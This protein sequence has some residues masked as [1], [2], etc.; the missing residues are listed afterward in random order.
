MA[1]HHRN[2][3]LNKLI[4]AIRK[5]EVV[6]WVGSG[7]SKSSGYPSGNE[8]S[9]MIKGK[10]TP[11]EQDILEKRFY[12]DDVAEEFCLLRPRDELIAIIRDV[13]KREP[14]NLKN[15][16]MVANIPQIKYLIT[17]NYDHLFE[18]VYGNDVY[19][20]VN[21]GDI[22]GIPNSGKVILYKIH[23]DI[24]DPD[25]I[26]ITKRDYLSFYQKGKDK[27][28][29]AQIRSLLSRYSVLLIGYSFEDSDI[30]YIFDDVI[31]KLGD[32]HKDIFLIS[33]NFPSHRLS[34]LSRRYSIQYLNSSAE[35]IMPKLSRVI[36]RQLKEDL[37]K[38]T[39]SPEEFDKI[40]KR[41]DITCRIEIID[42]RPQL[43]SVGSQENSFPVKGKFNMI[44]L[45]ADSGVLES[46]YELI[47]G[48][49]FGTVTLSTQQVEVRCDDLSVVGID[50]IGPDSH[51][52]ELEISSRPLKTGDGE[53]ILRS[54]GLHYPIKYNSY[55]SEFS[56]KVELIH[57][58]F[59]LELLPS[60]SDIQ[61]LTFN[62]V[63]DN[64]RTVS[65][66]YQ[67]YS[68]FKQWMNDTLLL[69]VQG[70]TEP[71][72]SI[73]FNHVKMPDKN[74]ASI[75][76][77]Y[78]LFNALFQIQNRFKVYFDKISSITE[79][80]FETIF[81]IKD[82]IDGKQ[83]P[84]SAITASEMTIYNRELFEKV[85]QNGTSAM[86]V[87]SN[88]GVTILGKSIKIPYVIYIHDPF[89]MNSEEIRNGLDGNTSNVLHNLEI[90]SRSG[91]MYAKY[92]ESE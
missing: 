62:G 66:G 25:S 13:F 86:K 17:T 20:V 73:A 60:D 49:R 24:D 41:S 18:R 55:L 12:L 47:Q 91:N 39:V 33:P 53:L 45:Q 81:L 6:L 89:F 80:D 8:L 65:Q 79:G 88:E 21:D 40:L 51:I 87:S 32:S 35:K 83:V 36:R 30:Q 10:L 37:E 77:T 84:V 5:G 14:S 52:S 67:V 76:Q 50:L 38:G 16:E 92:V 31:G 22:P 15:Q 11:Q 1:L 9:E 82:L 75:N 78:D 70:N 42:G 27:L 69:F 74:K 85:M 46:F 19:K 7:F 48:K 61:T 90:R 72:L 68:F 4:Q 26:V 54:S 29:W 63:I 57:P 34:D 58:Q 64:I 59:T 2:N 44:S 28:V 23:G 3:S 71:L 56:F 43:V